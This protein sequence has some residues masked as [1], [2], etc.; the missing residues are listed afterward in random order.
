MINA[1][2]FLSGCVLLAALLSALHFLR[3][4]RDTK[5]RFFLLF[6]FAFVLLGLERLPLLFQISFGDT[7]GSFYLIRLMAFVMILGAI[8]DKNLARKQE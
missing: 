7:N 3:F 6:S 2:C 8:I 1:N 5:D 4:W